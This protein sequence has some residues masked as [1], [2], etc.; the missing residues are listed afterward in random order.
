MKRLVKFV[1]PI[2]LVGTI[3]GCGNKD[4]LST[5]LNSISSSN[6]TL[7]SDY[8]I[9]C[10]DPNDK[11]N[12]YQELQR[13]D[14]ISKFNPD[15]YELI[16]YN[17][18]E[19][20]IAS[21]A[22]Y[23]KDAE[24]YIQS[25]TINDQNI[26]RYQY[27]LDANG[28]R[29][30]F[31]ESV[32][33]SQIRKL[34]PKDF[35]SEGKGVYNYVGDLTKLP[36]NILH[37]AIPTSSF[38]IESFKLIVKDGA[39]DS[40]VYQEVEDASIFEETSGDIYGRKLTIK[41][42]DIDNTVINPIVSYEDKEENN[43]LEAA[44]SNMKNNF[45]YTIKSSAIR[46]DGTVIDLSST[47]ITQNNM[48]RIDTN[49]NT[50]EVVTMGYHTRNNILFSVLSEEGILYGTKM[51]EDYKLEADLPKF[52]F[53]ENIFVFKEELDG[54]RYYEL[55]QNMEIILDKIDFMIGYSDNYYSPAG[56]VIFVVENNKLSSI[57]F[58]IY[59]SFNEMPELVTLVISYSDYGSTSIDGDVWKTF[60]TDIPLIPVYYSWDEVELEIEGLGEES[61]ITTAD[62][63][64]NA[65]LGND[66]SSLP[67]FLPEG[68]EYEFYANVSAE[69]DDNCTY[70]SIYAEG[71][72]DGSA[73]HIRNTLERAG[74]KYS[75]LSNDTGFKE[76]SFVLGNIDI[77]VAVIDNYVL[78]ITIKLPRINSL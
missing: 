12:G 67:F 64:I 15:L 37:A 77:I 2:L 43:P 19:D 52:S 72:V 16:A 46:E 18:G 27:A 48:V 63:I 47:Y 59:I 41:I 68:N 6:I 57:S 56:K 45:N 33:C 21:F 29:I 51:D 39:F 28:E 7:R 69:K 58:P 65:A 42:L 40:F 50:G 32:Y 20:L 44:I 66:A 26:V 17:Y 24:G 61:I 54:K 35:K 31:D 1:L 36:L 3:S 38:N 9:Y 11:V 13:F 8:E 62:A 4:D 14:V 78:D 73:G 10:Y 49:P 30:P 76:L 25:A 60:T 75:L 53:S 34:N 23:E 22:H 70:L 55:R 74:F 5:I 71:F